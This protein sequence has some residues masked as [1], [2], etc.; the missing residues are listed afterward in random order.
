MAPKRAFRGDLP[1]VKL[2]NFLKRFFVSL[3]GAC[4]HSM[5]IDMVQTDMDLSKNCHLHAACV[6]TVG[7]ACSVKALLVQRE[8]A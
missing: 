6:C 4:Q 2:G 8:A 5:G 7:A 3:S 1:K